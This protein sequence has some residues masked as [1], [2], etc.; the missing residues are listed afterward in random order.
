MNKR[1]HSISEGA[2]IELLKRIFNN[3]SRDTISLDEAYVAANR[4]TESEETNRN[5]L[6]HALTKLR[7]HKLVVPVYKYD[8]RQRLDKIQLT[9]AGKTA[10]GQVH[11]ESNKDHA[12]D[13]STQIT[14]SPEEVSYNDV[15]KVVRVFRDNNPEYE[16][17]FNVRLREEPM[18]QR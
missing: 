1:G 8:G 9:L 5:W 14:K 16:V 18:K 15:V 17:I 6:N 4:T 11:I 13:D 12:Q 3:T 2:A 10:L 7:Y